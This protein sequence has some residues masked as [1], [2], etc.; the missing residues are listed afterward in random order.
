MCL[1]PL[2]DNCDMNGEKGSKKKIFK[3]TLVL[4]A[5]MVVTML[6]SLYTSRIVLKALGIE[7][8][9]LYNVVGGVV[10]LFS[11]LKTSL[12]SATQRFMSYEMGRTDDEADTN[13]VFCASVTTH[14][15]L[16]GVIFLF[17][18]SLGLW[19]LNSQVNIPEGREFAANVIYHFSVVS[20]CVS[21][22][23]VPFHACVISHEDMGFFAFIS[24]LDALLKL[25]IAMAV[26]QITSADRLIYYGLL[27][28]LITVVNQVIYNIFCRKAYVECHFRFML[29]KTMVGR[30]FSFS[31]WS[32][33][34]QLAVM[35]SNH[36]AS[37][38]VN[39]FYSVS[40]N[41]AIG[42]AQQANHAI[43]GLVAN[44]QTAY[45]P[46]ITKAY[47]SN[48]YGYQNQLILQASKISFFLMFIVSLPVIFN[49][50]DLLN[51]WLE[52][53]PEGASQFCVFFMIASMLNA[54]GGPLWMSIFATGNIKHY[55]IATTAAYLSD[56]VIVYILFRIGFPP[57]TAVVV[58]VIV[59]A[60]VIFIRM[61]YCKKAISFFSAK[62]FVECVLL[63][64][65]IC[66]AL[67]V[68]IGYVVFHFAS[69]LLLKILAS[70]LILVFSMAISY[71]IGLSKNEK[72]A[73][74]SMVYGFIHKRNNE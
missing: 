26:T 21:M 47:A 17:C 6:I 9:G 51:L 74:N 60:A 10:A 37:I 49:I 69:T 64:L 62:E 31:S 23:N 68:F 71:A 59:N 25:G 40:A 22:L 7:D 35:A 57:V 18:E 5:R 1:V 54:I 67:S 4:Y 38:L 45:Q 52:T 2:P 28:M 11:F 27:I 30:I 50:D 73:I 56:V 13:R 65:A 36:G 24:I 58:K 70:F 43:S 39:I 63:P 61:F 41:A 72:K 66:A 19:F 20:I 48:N 33:L 42:V 16:A 15:M 32:L 46:Q 53:V 12:A 55:Q 3:N 44:F 29:D 14:I 34:G 8:Y